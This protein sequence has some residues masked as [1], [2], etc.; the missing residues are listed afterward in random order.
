MKSEII[1]KSKIGLE[2]LIPLILLMGIV[3]AVLVI[4]AVWPGLFICGVVI[5]LLINIYTGTFYKITP[6]NKLLVKCGVLETVGIDIM[7]IES[8]RQ[9][10]DLLGA[11]ALSFDRIVITYRGGQVVVSPKNKEGFISDLRR[12]NAKISL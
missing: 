10:R 8:I 7:K 12:I 2:I 1:Y 5:L 4:N 11:P 9:T 6:D 3:V